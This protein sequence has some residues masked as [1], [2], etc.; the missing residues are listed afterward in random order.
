VNASFSD[1]YRAVLFDMDGT[2]LDTLADIGNSM[3]TVL[4][5]MGFPVHELSAYKRFVGEGMALLVQR[6]LPKQK[7]GDEPLVSRCTSLMREE[8]AAHCMDATKAYPGVQELLADLKLKN[9]AI[10]VLSN[11]PDDMVQVLLNKYFPSISFDAA[12]G[13]GEKYPRKPDPAGALAIARRLNFP[14]ACFILLG[15]SKT[16][17]ETARAAGMHP[18]GALWGFRD[19][20]EL[21]EYGAKALIKKPGELLTVFKIN[22]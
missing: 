21:L 15:D 2:L 7:G 4:A 17:M 14:P 10:A 3:N 8:Y 19:E 6:A 16:D 11:K 13:A 12:L 5:R 20:R 9:V 18:V 1:T 22:C